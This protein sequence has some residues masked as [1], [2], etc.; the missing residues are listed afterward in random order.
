MKP[1]FE[2]IHPSKIIQTKIEHPR[3]QLA[4]SITS[5]GNGYMGCRGNYEEYYTGDSLKGTYIAGVWV[6]DKTRVG[7]WKNGYPRYYGKV[8]NA[9]DFLSF[10]LYLDGVRFDLAKAELTSFYREVD[11][12]NGIMTRKMTVHTEKGS[13]TV[14]SSRFFSIARREIAVL[15]YQFTSIDYTGE[16]EIK[17]SLDGDVTNRDANYGEKFWEILHTGA[18]DRLTLTARTKENDFAIER[19]TICMKAETSCDLSANAGACSCSDTVNELQAVRSWRFAAV[20]GASASLH[21]T[22]SVV[23]SRD[24]AVQDLPDT[25]DRLLSSAVSAGHSFLVREQASAWERRWRMCDVVIE[26][27]DDAQQGIRFN[28]FHLWNTYDGTDARLNVGPKGF[29][30]EKYGGAAYYDTEGYCFPMYL[31]TAGPEVARN[32][33][34]FR[35]NTLEKAKENAAKIGMKGALYPMVTFNGEECHNEWEITF[36]ELH[37][38]AAMV[39]AIYCYTQYTGDETYIR[40]FGL[41]VMLEVSRFWVSRCSYNAAKDC[42]MLLGV[43]APNEYENNVN[44][45][46][47]TNYMA[48]WCIDY[49]L[50]NIEKY[51][52]AVAEEELDLFRKVSAKMY[53]GTTR[54]DGLIIQQDGYL[55]K[56]LL[57]VSA[58]PEEELPL[59]KHWS[60]DR[61]LRSC[62]IKQADVIL[63]FYYFPDRFSAEQKKVNFDFYEPMTVHESS[64]SPSMYSVV[65]SHCGNTQDAYR[66]YKRAARLDLDNFNDDTDDGLHIT[67]MA[68]SWLAIVHGF[69]GLNFHGEYLAFNPACPECW[70]S[71]G[72]HLLYRGR[73]LN[74]SFTRD[75]F[76]CQILEGEGLSLKV[77]GTVYEVN[78][79]LTVPLA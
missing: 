61:I 44:N 3:N 20:P 33:L 1:I 41:S 40:D 69:A 30:G 76:T 75:S 14:E 66:L 37:R 27:D 58:I 72:F 56:E 39:Y 13:F 25:A 12:L 74:I 28:L 68:G 38:N 71:V 46:W 16:V 49:T 79:R 51:H 67:S 15:T 65:A 77:R 7:W 43:S 78:D 47:L 50:E 9:P 45:N 8:I 6:P 64:L 26:G 48:K 31:A 2:T 34:L 59:C 4:E 54:E 60:W 29:T 57:P 42:Y 11:L 22:V 36:E 53:M 19:F 62:Y 70:N 10:D 73:L 35:Y 32:L 17:S 55:D 52:A 5:L 63:G 23:T 18:D 24:Y 21:K